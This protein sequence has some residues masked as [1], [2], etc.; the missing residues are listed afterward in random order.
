MRLVG[1]IFGALSA[2]TFSV[3]AADLRKAPEEP[4]APVAV[5]GDHRALSLGRRQDHL[6]AR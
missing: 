5:S 4:L 1:L 3:S 2:T 6:Y